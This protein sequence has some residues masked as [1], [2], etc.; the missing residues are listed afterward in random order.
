[1]RVYCG[2]REVVIA[3]YYV[4]AD[5]TLLT[6]THREAQKEDCKNESK[7]LFHYFKCTTN[8]LRLVETRPLTFRVSSIRCQCLSYTVI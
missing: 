7:E 3:V 4:S 2:Q 8:P 6:E 1:M 5:C